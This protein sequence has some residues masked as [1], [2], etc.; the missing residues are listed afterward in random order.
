MK[1]PRYHHPDSSVRARL[2]EWF[3]NSPGLSLLE[4]EC[5]QINQ[6]LPDLFG[7][8]IIQVGTLGSADLLVSSRISHR[9]VINLYPGDATLDASGPICLSGA[10]PVASECVDV[11]VLPHLLE[12]E[13]DPR[14]ILRETE[15]ILIGEGHLVIIG[16]NP[17]S[18]WGLWRAVLAWRTEPPWCGQ[19]FGIARIKGWLALL[20]FDII[21]ARRFYFQPPLPSEGVMSKFDFLESLGRTCWPFLG[22]AYIVVAKKRVATLTPIKT[23]WRA[24]R[25]I[26]TSGIAEPST[27]G[28]EGV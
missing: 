10:L 1:S 17:W 15:R 5:Q 27:R 22:G 11:V 19:F 12:F 21:K 7:Y 4:G 13:S 24:Q 28:I 9:T 8:H 6:V 18:L 20:G 23:S 26:I 25:Q 2:N 14:Q 3:A 16:F